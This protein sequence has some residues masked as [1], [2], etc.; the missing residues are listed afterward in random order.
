MLKNKKLL[1]I[2]L[3]I[4]IVLAL[5]IGGYS[6]YYKYTQESG[7]NFFVGT[8]DK[9]DALEDSNEV[10]QILDDLGNLLG[11]SKRDDSY[12]KDGTTGGTLSPTI[13]G[14]TI[15]GITDL[16]VADGGTGASTASAARANLVVIYDS[17]EVITISHLKDVNTPNDEEI[18]TYEATT[19]DF[20]WHTL[21]ELG[22]QPLDTG[23]TNLAA[24][25]YV[26][27]S[28]IK[29]IATD[30]YAIRTLAEVRTDLG[31]V[32]GTNVMAWDAQL[33]DIAA[34]TYTDGNFIV[35]D[36]SNWVAESG[37]TARAS[38]GLGNVENLKVKLDAIAAPGVGND[39]TEGYAVGSRWI[40]ITNDKEY[41]ALDVSTGAAVWTETTGAGGGA[42]TFTGLTDTP[43][44]YTG[45]A[46]KYI[47]VNVGEDALE[48]GTPTGGAGTYLELT[49]TPAAYDNGK[50][51]KSTAAGVV[52]DDPAGIGDMTKAVYDTDTDNIVDKAETVDD[53]VG[54]S[55]TAAD[56]KDAITKKHTQNTDIAAG[57]EWNFGAHSAGFTVQTITS[58]E[59]TATINW[60]NS[61]KARITLSEN[62]T[63]A[64]TN[65]ANSGNY[66]LVIIQP[67]GSNAYTTTFPAGIYWANSTKV[68]VPTA[69]NNRCIVS[70]L[71][72][73]EDGDK[74][75]CQGT[76]TFAT[77]D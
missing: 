39:N 35:G 62:T 1:G 48:F 23:L 3:S 44:N 30:T 51:A 10:R 40:D 2:L 75:Y 54:N 66:M 68:S 43:A 7:T 33:D 71:F 9:A 50:Y 76:D 21:A 20:E 41:V 73:D 13:I 15:T 59:G 52:W 63:L 42:T 37:S 60:G 38:L 25:T 61:N 19:G 46:G 56:V 4:V 6:A 47:K 65:P 36:G 31:L 26:S 18:F 17:G 28:F 58:S 14:G 45:Q 57:G 11:H 74:W 70:F 8:A 55:S 32:I 22:I 69:D 34:L 27:D 12:P 5:S 16:A 64:F 49:D 53:G 72:D 29:V 77:D 67:A 24:L